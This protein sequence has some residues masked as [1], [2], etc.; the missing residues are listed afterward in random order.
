MAEQHTPK[1]H[2]TFLRQFALASAEVEKLRLLDP[3]CFD[4]NGRA[5]V[6]EARLLPPL[7]NRQTTGGGKP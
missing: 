6:A 1:L 4:E 5:I 3:G 7:D 2:E